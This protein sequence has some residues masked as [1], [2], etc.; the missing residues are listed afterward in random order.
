VLERYAREDGAQVV[1]L[2]PPPA[3]VAHSVEVYEVEVVEIEQ[4]I[5]LLREQNGL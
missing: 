5:T 2:D 4:F 3:P 1:V